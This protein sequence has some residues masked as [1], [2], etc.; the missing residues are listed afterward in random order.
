M[1]QMFERGITPAVISKGN[2]IMNLSVTEYNINFSDSFLYIKT[3]LSKC[4]KLYNLQTLKGTFPLA[5]NDVQYYEAETI[6]NFKLFLS[7]NDSEQAL[8]DKS[9]WYLIR[10]NQPWNFKKEICKFMIKILPEK[11]LTYFFQ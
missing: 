1:S 9:E 2:A 7:E 11:I 3:S 6:P 8:K 10:K 5:G 4:C